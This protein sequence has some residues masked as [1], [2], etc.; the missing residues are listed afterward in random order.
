[1]AHGLHSACKPLMEWLKPSTSTSE[2][3]SMDIISRP[4]PRPEA[5]VKPLEQPNKAILHTELPKGSSL[6]GV[7]PSSQINL[8]PDSLI[9]MN[10]RAIAKM[11]AMERKE[12]SPVKG[13]SAARHSPIVMVAPTLPKSTPISFIW[14]LPASFA[15]D[16]AMPPS[17]VST[18]WCK[19]RAVSMCRAGNH[20]THRKVEAHPVTD[21]PISPQAAQLSFP[22]DSE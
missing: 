22:L 9:N 13:K 19:P 4:S 20:M 16:R 18:T 11:P 6:M 3:A 7:K 14:V 8:A 21:A 5:C 12:V 15:K 10:V 2:M 1:M 17:Q